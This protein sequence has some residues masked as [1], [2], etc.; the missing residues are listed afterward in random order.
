MP[1]SNK[2]E[3]AMAIYFATA[4][5]ITLLQGIIFAQLVTY[6][7]STRTPHHRHSTGGPRRSSLPHL[8]RQGMSTTFGYSSDDQNNRDAEGWARD[9]WWGLRGY[10]TLIMAC[11]VF[12]TVCQIVKSW[13]FV[14]NSADWVSH[15]R[16]KIYRY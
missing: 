16:A 7:S 2:V 1:T 6:Y 9:R 5:G 11:C 3:D 14:R 10:T 15:H 12:E 13:T 8:K 4:L